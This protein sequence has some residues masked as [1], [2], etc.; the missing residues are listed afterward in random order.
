[1]KLS[2][3]IA[4]LPCC[5]VAG[6]ETVM[7][8]TSFL[9]VVK[10]AIDRKLTISAVKERTA[11]LGSASKTCFPADDGAEITVNICCQFVQQVSSF[12]RVGELKL[13]EGIPEIADLTSKNHNACESLKC[14]VIFLGQF[15]QLCEENENLHKH[16]RDKGWGD[17]ALPAVLLCAEHNKSASWTSQE[18]MNL[19]R[20]ATES[21]LQVCKCISVEQLFGSQANLFGKTMKQLM[22]SLRKETWK[23]NPAAAQSFAYLLQKVSTPDCGSFPHCL[24]RVMVLVIKFENKVLDTNKYASSA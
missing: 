7:D 12:G 20:T 22:P 21:V 17:L 1:M 2:S 10:D 3:I 11:A 18:S 8:R 5:V 14:L 15:K 4:Q 13:D 19:A 9:D 24:P 23:N 16:E 6:V